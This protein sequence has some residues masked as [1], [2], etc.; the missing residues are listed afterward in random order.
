MRKKSVIGKGHVPIG[1]IA[2][3]FPAWGNLHY[4]C[5]GQFCTRIVG[6][7]KSRI[8]LAFKN[9][10]QKSIKITDNRLEIRVPTLPATGVTLGCYEPGNNFPLSI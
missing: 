3:P 8:V 5:L 6:S 2:F 7:K 1:E 10:D 9:S 4:Y